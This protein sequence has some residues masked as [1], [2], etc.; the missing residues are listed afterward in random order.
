MW[1]KI[2]DFSTHLAPSEWYSSAGTFNNAAYFLPFHNISY[3]YDA[4][5]TRYQHPFSSGV[6]LYYTSALAVLSSVVIAAGGFYPFEFSKS[7]YIFNTTSSGN[8]IVISNFL[9][10]G[11]RNVAVTSILGLHYDLAIFAGGFSVIFGDSYDYN[12]YS[13]TEVFNSSSPLE[14]SFA[15]NSLTEPRAYI[16]AT[17]VGNFA[18]F[19]GG[20][21]KGELAYS[22]SY[23]S[24]I[25]SDV[26]DIY[27]SLSNTWFS[28]TLNSAR[29]NITAFT[30]GTQAMF[31]GGFRY[32]SR[33]A[34]FVFTN[35][36]DIYDDSTQSWS[37]Q[38]RI[39][40]NAWMNSAVYGRLAI[41]AGGITSNFVAASDIEVYDSDTKLWYL[42]NSGLSYS[43][44]SIGTAVVNSVI[45]LAGG[46]TNITSQNTSLAIDYLTFA[47]CN[48]GYYIAGTVCLNCTAGFYSLGNTTMCISCS[49]GIE[50]YFFVDDIF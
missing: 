37:T 46:Q 9:N 8:A 23:T 27:N 16:G 22:D 3:L 44:Y 47:Y 43:R 42:L 40:D 28:H 33:Y 25:Y 6:P 2:S 31:A 26:V 5:F 4:S 12:Y 29:A 30:I 35:L 32:E 21:R 18:L 39:L 24:Q 15:S 14:V 34:E 10:Q 17:S 19:A 13:S 41:L 50:C 48:Y 11:R 49:S 36:V 7:A 45:I 1:S 38:L 20:S